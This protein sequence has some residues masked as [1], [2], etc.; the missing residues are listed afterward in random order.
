MVSFDCQLNSGGKPGAFVAIRR[1]LWKAT[2]SLVFMHGACT[3]RG[4]T[5]PNALALRAR[6]AAPVHAEGG[7]P[8]RDLERRGAWERLSLQR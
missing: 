4:G 7:Y 1:A 3:V 8:H 2:Q 6:F 5:I